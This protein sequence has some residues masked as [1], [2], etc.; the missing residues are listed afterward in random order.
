MAAFFLLELQLIV[1]DLR[2]QGSDLLLELEFSATKLRVKVHVGLQC[3]KLL[4]MCEVFLL[5]KL[6]E[7]LALEQKLLFEF[8]FLV[9]E[10]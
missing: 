8:L 7:L 1:L 10:I 3:F 9:K 4:L 2:L 5:D 6:L